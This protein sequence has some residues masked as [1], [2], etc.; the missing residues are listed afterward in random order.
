M[1][2]AL[3]PSDRGRRLNSNAGG[4]TMKRILAT[5]ILA[6]AV[7]NVSAGD[8]VSQSVL[9]WV[10]NREANAISP[11]RWQNVRKT[12]LGQ[13]GGMSLDAME[14]IYNRRVSNGWAAG[15]WVP[16]IA[17]V[18]CLQTVVEEVEE[19]QPV[20]AEAPPAPA[21]AEPEPAQESPAVDVSSPPAAFANFDK[22]IKDAIDIKIKK[23]MQVDGKWQWV[24]VPGKDDLYAWNKWGPW[25]NLPEDVRKG[26]HGS[27]GQD[28]DALA[29]GTYGPSHSR[30]WRGN[31]DMET[32]QARRVATSGAWTWKGNFTNYVLHPN[33]DK[34]WDVKGAPP[35]MLFRFT[36][37]RP[38]YDSWYA[39]VVY[40]KADGSTFHGDTWVGLDFVDGAVRTK[41]KSSGE[42]NDG[43]SA[44]FYTHSPFK[45]D[46]TEDD[47][48]SLY[49]VGEVRR[50][51]II[52][53]FITGTGS[54][55]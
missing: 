1:G 51:K 34:H 31:P 7:V 14:V 50:P 36:Y 12:L 53:T 11:T 4:L 46:H 41:N 25:D 16:I 23:R 27:V 47:P 33:V 39:A 35:Q 44:Q 49:L 40:T 3:N 19:V 29:E 54:G 15:H 2:T 52:G 9:T 21:K 30:I 42:G 45:G 20:Q 8:C 48:F 26:I 37:D 13:D 10:D 17:A 43:L 55:R 32:E 5:A 18:K 38:D 22:T 28:W 24:E 6:M